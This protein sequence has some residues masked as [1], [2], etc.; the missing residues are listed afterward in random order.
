MSRHFFTFLGT[1]VLGAL[2]ALAARAAWFNPNADHTGHTSGGGDYVP[3]VA[4]TRPTADAHASHQSATTASSEIKSAPA[5][6]TA[7][8]VA[9]VNSICAI[10]GM[11]VDPDLPTAEYQ[12]KTI[13]FGCKACPAIFKANP[14]KYGPAYLRNEVVKG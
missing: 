7:T 5:S 8:T 12:G 10:C 9:P 11:E 13:G 2:I 3:M 6:P 14:D 4:N 1:F